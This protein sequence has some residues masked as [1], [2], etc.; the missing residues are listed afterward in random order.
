[1]RALLRLLIAAAG[2]AL[3]SIGS[4]GTAA[5]LDDELRRLAAQP[6]LAYQLTIQGCEQA[7]SRL[8]RGQSATTD[9]IMA[10]RL[11]GTLGQSDQ[12]KALTLLVSLYRT[13]DPDTARQWERAREL[14]VVADQHLV[15]DEFD[16]AF[17]AAG[18]AL[19][20]SRSINDPVREAQVLLI[21][22]IGK[23]DKGELGSALAHADA[24][25]TLYRQIHHVLGA[26]RTAATLAQVHRRIENYE[27]S[28]QYSQSA[29]ML[30]ARADDTETTFAG[31]A[32][33]GLVYLRLGQYRL[34]LEHLSSAL[35]NLRPGAGASHA[36][37]VVLQNIGLVYES[38]RMYPEAARQFQG[39]LDV[40][41]DSGSPVLRADIFASLGIV[42]NRLGDRGRAKGYFISALSRYKEYGLCPSIATVQSNLAALAVDE[43]QPEAALAQYEIVEKLECAANDRERLSMALLGKAEALRLLG[44]TRESLLLATRACALTNDRKPFL[45]QCSRAQALAHWTLGDL[46]AA[47]VHY[48]RAVNALEQ[49]HAAFGDPTENPGEALFGDLRHYYLEAIEVA[50]LLHGREPGA[51]HDR[52][53]FALSERAKSRVFRD[54]IR[55]TGMRMRGASD[56]PFQALLTQERAA[57]A[58]VVRFSR[59]ART[60]PPDERATAEAARVQASERLERMRAQLRK[61][62]PAYRDI[63]QP[64]L[65]RIEQIQA[66]LVP[67]KALVSYALGGKRSVAFVIRQKSFSA[68]PLAIGEAE[69]ASRIAGLR[70]QLEPPGRP[71]AAAE[72]VNALRGF[73]PAGA[74]EMYRQV[75]APFAA[76]LSG[77]KRVYVA[78]DGALF[79]LPF[80]ALVEPAYD[81]A[82]FRAEREQADGERAPSLSEYGSV[83][84]LGRRYGF[85][86]LPAASSMVYL[87]A[88]T[89][90]RATEWRTPLIAFADPV[91]EDEEA[92]ESKP[93]RHRRLPATAQEARAVAKLLQ[94]QPENVYLRERASK[95]NV[96][97]ARLDQARYV[98][99]A[100]HGFAG[101][102]YA[103]GAEPALLLARTGA[104]QPQDDLLTMSEVIGL[105]LRAEL[106]VLS[107][108]STAGQPSR[109][110]Q[111]GEGFAGVARSFMYAGSRA[112]LVTHW[113]VFDT[114]AR[115]FVVEFFKVAPGAG[116]DAAL[117]SAVKARSSESIVDES[118]GRKI[119]VAHPTFW[120]GYALV[121]D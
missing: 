8:A 87:R 102:D 118:S 23:K 101:A 37:G 41:G 12:A 36:R 20:I 21:I 32:N 13:Y 76:A 72:L 91:F 15:N 45:A 77:A 61:D 84:W 107:A 81:P 60:S 73:D 16:A 117:A 27:L 116:A 98:L 47:N 94:A 90:A 6:D 114:L 74:L 86:Y 40:I 92:A 119:S 35:R 62:Y 9:F 10:G 55:R 34:A 103:G 100:T 106:T 31:W 50:M 67:E 5:P 24:A 30:A 71:L 105:E 57:V 26:G 59:I 108:C 48:L 58:H 53:A 70:A 88:G 46:E 63:E 44:R 11:A 113:S 43:K 79:L 18:A 93:G 54:Q 65:L 75:F 111:Y 33:S 22:A 7:L 89:H 4:P 39:A 42:H 51:G 52:N 115:D 121:G 112:V 17:S 2:S 29:R 64:D 38:I 19:T 56:A 1:M 110:E 66:V 85:R 49:V 25:M 97:A 83:P 120:A 109:A 104:A 80:G 69:V 82:R 96:H 78:G 68:V 14:A 28:L 99:F 3:V 95:A